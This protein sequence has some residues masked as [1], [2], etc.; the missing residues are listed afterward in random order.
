MKFGVVFPQ[1]EFGGDAGAVREYTQAV[2]A[3]GFTHVVAYDHVIGANP[4]RPGG[5]TGVYTY[6]H[7]FLEP[8]VLF[9]FMAGVSRKLGFLTGITI[10]PQRQTVLA[11]K[12]AATLDVLCQ[13]RFRFGIGLGWNAVEY[14]ALN[15]DFHTRGRRMEEQVEVLRLLWTEPLVT[16]K[17][18][19]HLIPDAGINPLPVQRPIPI[20]IGGSSPAALQRI[21]RIGDGWLP[22]FRSIDDARKAME[23]L[24]R[25]LEEDGR[26]PSDLGIEPRIAY[27]DGNPET[28]HQWIQDWQAL[29]AAQFSINT[30][31]A[32][33][34]TP[35]AHL[36]A[37]Q[38]FVK[39]VEFTPA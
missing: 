23:I 11:A 34:K 3:M 17:G 39:S 37:L 29:G 2:E 27:G 28:W 32:G 38:K 14:A 5:W 24:R 12:Q 25:S 21:A 19:W 20:W 18:K 8:F 22:N 10:L 13:G 4:E 6:K 30:L 7:S 36:E 16:F 15:E 31:G 9:S 33:F 26:K 1:T 35:Q